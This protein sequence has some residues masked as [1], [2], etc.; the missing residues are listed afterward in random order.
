VAIERLEANRRHHL[1]AVSILLIVALL[2][3]FILQRQITADPIVG[4]GYQN[5]VTASNLAQ[6]GVFSSTPGGTPDMLREPGWPWLLS[7][8]IKASPLREAS[9]AQLASDYAAVLKWM[10][11]TLYA[12]MSGVL[13]A[14]VFLRLRSL[15]AAAMAVLLGLLLY[16]TTPRLINYLNN[17]ALATLLLLLASI[18]FHEVIR[19]RCSS[20]LFVWP[21][22]LGALW[23]CLA[24]S[25][26]QFLY[27]CILPLLVLGYFQ[28]T[29]FAM[30]VL[31]F[32]LLVSPWL[33]RNETLFDQP[34]LAVRGKAVLAVR[35]ALTVEPTRKERSCMFFAFT[36]PALQ[37]YL[38]G[39]WG[40]TAEDFQQGG[41]CQ[42]LNREL[43]F[44]MGEKKVS[45]APFREDLANGDWQSKV[46]YFYRGYALGSLIDAGQLR[47][48]DAIHI[49]T[50]ML[51]NYLETLPLFF[52]RGLGV[53]GFPW[54][55]LG[56]FLAEG[57]L[58]FTSRWPLALLSVSAH[59]FHV[60]LT[61]NMPRYHALEYPIM[62]LS[63]VCLAASLLNWFREKRKAQDRERGLQSP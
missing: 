52:W 9:V 57:L 35:L 55:A 34:S 25:K 49:D 30:A 13:A 38:K 18:L 6:L 44:D 14:Y 58:L 40:I 23:G 3:G 36:H 24:L 31:G 5:L 43:C 62:A 46:Q 50:S 8:F 56:L 20:S 1:A 15:S 7:L 39:M 51:R 22:V 61:H 4:D 19:G 42:R 45:C 28:R 53:S 27:I 33:V 11:V 47:F 48:S 26:A 59:A 32:A 29:K 12:L 16:A 2:S 60:L 63:A 21:L 10:N 37:H 41:R 54:L 17:E